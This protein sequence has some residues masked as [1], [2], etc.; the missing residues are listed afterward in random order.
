MADWTSPLLSVGLTRVVLQLPNPFT[1]G[2]TG[3]NV[4]RGDTIQSVDFAIY[5]T[6]V[7]TERHRA[8]FRAEFFNLPNHPDFGLPRTTINA[9]NPGRV[10]RA[11]PGRIIQF[12]VKYYF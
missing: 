5:K 1:F 4:L 7:I 11:S 12:G 6:F 3:R 8:Q 2:N 9:A 10:L